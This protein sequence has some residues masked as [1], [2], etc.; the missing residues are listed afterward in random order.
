MLATD[1][2]VPSYIQSP[3][4]RPHFEHISRAPIH[5]KSIGELINTC[6]C[7]VWS[8]SIS[9]I[10]IIRRTEFFVTPTRRRL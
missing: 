7:H 4:D 8:P 2:T 10:S 5:F 9:Q 6:I 1:H 3:L